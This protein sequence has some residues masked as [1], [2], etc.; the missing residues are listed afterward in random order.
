VYKEIELSQAKSSAK[1]VAQH[2]S[3]LCAEVA[4]TIES[5]PGQN[6]MERTIELA[7]RIKQMGNALSFDIKMLAVAH[8]ALQ[9][10]THGKPEVITDETR[11]VPD[12]AP[13]V[14]PSNIIQRMEGQK[15]R[16]GTKERRSR[17]QVKTKK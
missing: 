14:V 1:T 10:L 12:S 8:E 4:K 6:S 13:T 11:R 5:I 17:K 2:M 3:Y 15:D 16:T 7:D 9:T